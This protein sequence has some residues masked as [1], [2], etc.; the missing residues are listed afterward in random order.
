MQHSLPTA[1]AALRLSE[2]VKR[3]TAGRQGVCRRQ[4]GVETLCRTGLKSSTA[5]TCL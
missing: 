4:D 5:Q 2:L 1:P 3:R